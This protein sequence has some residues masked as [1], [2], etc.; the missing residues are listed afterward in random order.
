M[1]G[2]IIPFANS[3]KTDPT[4]IGIFLIV[5]YSKQILGATVIRSSFSIVVQAG[6]L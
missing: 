2:S 5:S 3:F 6:C 1:L 4:V